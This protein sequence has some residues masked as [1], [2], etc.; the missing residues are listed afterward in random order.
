V[1]TT[2]CRSDCAAPSSAWIAGRATLTTAMSR[3]SMK[4]TPH[5]SARINA[6][7]LGLVAVVDM[8]LLDCVVRV[9]RPSGGL[10]PLRPPRRRV[11]IAVTTARVDSHNNHGVDTCGHRR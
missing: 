8:D 6:G 7:F 11:V 4:L 9:V 10:F 1:M 3:L 5:T 2:H